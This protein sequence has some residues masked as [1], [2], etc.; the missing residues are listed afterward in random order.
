MLVNIHLNGKLVI[1][2]KIE[3]LIHYLIEILH[4]Y[5]FIQKKKKKGS[6]LSSKVIDIQLAI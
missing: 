1:E 2:K 6:I 3:N 5:A 4:G